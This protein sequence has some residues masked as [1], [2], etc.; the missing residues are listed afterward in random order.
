M[1]A[2]K[3][4]HVYVLVGIA[5]LFMFTIGAFFEEGVAFFDPVYTTIMSDLEYY[6]SLIAVLLSVTCFL[7]LVHRFYTIKINWVFL[8]IALTLVV[9]NAVAVLTFPSIYTA[10]GMDSHSNTYSIVYLLTDSERVRSI[11][12]F[13]VTCLY[14]Y[15]T[16]VIV[17][18][19]LRSS[20][21][22]TL[23]FYGSIVLVV[24]AIIWSLIYERDIY[25]YYFNPDENPT[26][27]TVVMSFFNNRN[28]YGTMILMGVCACGYLQCQS[29]HWWNYLL[30]VVFSLELFFVISKTSM[31]LVAF[32]MTAFLI[33]RYVLTVKRHWI[34][35]NIVLV[36]I[37]SLIGFLTWEVVSGSIMNVPVLGKIAKNVMDTIDETGTDTIETRMIIWRICLQELNSP[38]RIIFGMGDGSFMWLL[39]PLAGSGQRLL[40]Y[41]HN[42][43]LAM[44]DYGGVI[45]LAAYIAMLVYFFVV[46]IQ[47]FRH[48]HVTTFVSLMMLLVFFI[49]GFV[50]T[51]SFMGADTKS[52]GLLIMVFLPVL[53]DHYQDKHKEVLSSQAE[54][55]ANYQK[56]K[57]VY[58]LTASEAA[59]VALW[60]A[61]PLFIL[62]IALFPSIPAINSL[63]ILLSVVFLYV[64]IPLYAM[65]WSGLAHIQKQ[66]GFIT[67]IVLSLLYLV[68][69]LLVP[70]FL[71]NFIGFVVSGSCQ[72]L[73]FILLYGIAH[74]GIELGRE[75]V[76]AD[77]YVPYLTLTFGLSILVFG[78]QLIGKGITPYVVMCLAVIGLIIYL[79]VT[80]FSPLASFFTY[81]LNEKWGSLERNAL[82]RNLKWENKLDWKISSYRQKKETR[83]SSHP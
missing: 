11:I 19:V 36:L 57:T 18:K 42:G 33:Y 2:A 5:M 10:V 3:A 29:R 58:A 6:L 38:M 26:S 65:C 48:K 16:L 17:P 32:F 39:G 37:L 53:T 41:T 13:A 27:S 70:F 56:S 43:L 25:M 7:F 23:Y 20:R 55:Y 50:E 52:L 82:Y 77:A 71:N 81:P 34:K 83:S 46:I 9:C 28:T 30:M 47:N 4:K 49:H 69:C 60:I 15:L 40:G 62:F 68:A 24:V 64:F 14:L 1:V 74:H 45:R 51:T 35:D 44:L 76:F 12:T 22:L 54:A 63:W 75:S 78:F 61:S 31:L 59:R 79:L 72:I 66:G 21:Q 67:G 8:S 73:L 80:T